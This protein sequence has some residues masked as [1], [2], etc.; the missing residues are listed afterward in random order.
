MRN[1]LCNEVILRETAKV[2][3]RCEMWYE[4]CH[5]PFFDRLFSF[6]SSFKLVL[7][8][9]F[10]PISTFYFTVFYQFFFLNILHIYIS[11]FLFVRFANLLLVF[12]R[13]FI[14]LKFILSCHFYQLSAVIFSFLL[15]FIN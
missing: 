2:A 8:S 9:L 10:S 3:Q 15:A 6:Y 1:T 13:I 11:A 12:S 4:D 7:S 14:C 5:T